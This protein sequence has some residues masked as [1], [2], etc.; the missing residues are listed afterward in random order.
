MLER[1]IILGAMLTLALPGFSACGEVDP[2]GAP[3]DFAANRGESVRGL[4]APQLGDP[5]ARLS[6]ADLARFQTGKTE[7][8]DTETPAD[9]LGPVF[10]DSSCGACHNTPAA[11]GSGDTIETRFG[12]TTNG[13]FDP[14]TELGGSL[15]QVRGIGPAGNCNFVGETVP[16][17]ATIQAGRRT[18]PLF[19]FGLV[20]AVPDSFFWGLA[21]QESQ[22]YPFE[23]GHPSVVRDL[24]TG[25][26]AVGRFGWKAQVPNLFQFSGDAYLNEMGITNPLFPDESCPQG[27]CDLLACNPRP[28]LNDDGTGLQRFTDFMSLLAPPV[29]LLS[30]NVG[31]FF[32]GQVFFNIGCDHCHRP[33]LISGS[34]PVPALA[35][36]VFTPFS[37]FLLHDMGSLGDGIA[38][39][40]A[41]GREMRTQP[42]WGLHAERFLLHDGRAT[43]IEAAILAHD[44]QGRNARDQ[45]ARLRAQDR[46]NLLAF[47]GTL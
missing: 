2:D 34:S 32:G 23:A 8:V 24:R 47:L 20:D 19:G 36:R 44:G 25:R 7:F 15:I 13:V 21:R 1:R 31:V 9:G 22:R 5:L 14:M 41:S 42:L 26:D 4:G 12:R 46:A 43:T 37:D 27:Q 11:G 18:T 29:P 17:T 28:D 35:N 3:G 33:T 30:R 38:Q 40:S 16:A 10:N 6:A 45:F 39:G